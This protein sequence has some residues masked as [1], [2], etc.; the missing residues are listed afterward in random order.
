MPGAR[1]TRSLVCKNEKTHERR[2]HRFTGSTRHSLRDGLTAYFVLS[3]VTGLVC[4]RRSKDD[5]LSAPGWADLS[6][7]NL[8]PASGRQDHTISPYALALFVRTP[9]NRS[10]EKPAL[11]SRCAP[12]A[13][14]S[15]ASRSTFVTT[16]RPPLLEG[17]GW[18][19]SSF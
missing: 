1:C 9:V 6:P 4:H 18:A 3:P 17:T 10:R 12:N 14:A 2:H 13:A 19:D 7:Q 16:A 11:R 15:I 8:T 5:D